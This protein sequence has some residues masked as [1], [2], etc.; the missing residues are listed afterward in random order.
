MKP[1]RKRTIISTVYKDDIRK[2]TKDK[3]TCLMYKLK[4]EQRIESFIPFMGS[5]REDGYA[6]Y[7][8]RQY[9]WPYTKTGRMNKEY[10][11][12]AKR[13]ETYRELDTMLNMCI[14]EIMLGSL[15]ERGILPLGSRLVVIIKRKK[16]RT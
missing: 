3:R 14:D 15:T 1:K 9:P 2:I 13:E 8:A 11:A 12:L 6:H 4:Q 7:G 10:G 16:A 5:L